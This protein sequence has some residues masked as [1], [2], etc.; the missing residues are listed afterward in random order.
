MKNPLQTIPTAPGKL[1]I[2]RL[3]GVSGWQGSKPCCLGIAENDTWLFGASALSAESGLCI[4]A[5]FYLCVI[6]LCYSFCAT[7]PW[8]N[9]TSFN[10]KSNQGRGVSFLS[11]IKR[12]VF[13]FALLVLLLSSELMLP[14]ITFGIQMKHGWLFAKITS[15]LIYLPLLWGIISFSVFYH[16]NKNQPKRTPAESILQWF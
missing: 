3:R 12:A 7:I 13:S 10:D 14:F 2:S 1:F 6:A 5:L 8:P 16:P 4:V 11:D 9:R 15:Q